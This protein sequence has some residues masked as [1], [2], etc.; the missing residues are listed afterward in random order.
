MYFRAVLVSDDHPFGRP[1]VG[2]QDHAI[3]W[4]TTRPQ[5]SPAPP[6]PRPAASAHAAAHLED[7]SRDGGARLAGR[8][9]PPP[10]LPELSLQER[11]PATQGAPRSVRAP[12]PRQPRTPP[13]LS[14][15]ERSCRSWIRR[16]GPAAPTPPPS[17]RCSVTA[18]LSTSG[19]AACARS[20]AGTAAGV[21]AGRSAAKWRW[22]LC[23]LSAAP[24]GAPR[25]ARP[26]DADAALPGSGSGAVGEPGVPQ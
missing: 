18:A 22:R 26:W 11:V 17:P 5:P 14:L 9:Q 7:D 23:A 25:G 10:L 8:G 15:T 24:C 6:G 1:R 2:P 3:L 20:G 12:R 16:S 4:D 21:G 13:A 19:A